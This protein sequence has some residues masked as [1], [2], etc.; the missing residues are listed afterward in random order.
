[1][2]DEKYIVKTVNAVISKNSDNHISSL[3]LGNTG[4]PHYNN[5][6]NIPK[7]CGMGLPICKDFYNSVAV[8]FP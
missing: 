6:I 8:G 3:V 5:G 2:I 4:K 1:M 7:I